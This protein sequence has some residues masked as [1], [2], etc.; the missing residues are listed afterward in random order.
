M[1]APILEALAAE[2]SAVNQFIDLLQDEGMALAG[3]SPLPQ[4]QDLAQRK[5]TVADTLSGLSDNR[6]AA[7]AAAGYAVGHAGGDAAA[8]DNAE[9]STAWGELL[10]A[11]T[12]AKALNE[13]NGGMIQTH[14]R[15]AQAA[16]R[17]VRTVTGGD[18]YGADGRHPGSA[19]RA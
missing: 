5:Q 18:L 10:E 1:S 7:L 15:G 3:R 8:Q 19:R 6:D 16:Q 4:L 9:V 2:A 13:R 17:A 11:A 12:T 14:L